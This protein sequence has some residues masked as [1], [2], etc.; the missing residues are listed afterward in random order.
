MHAANKYILK[1]S[2]LLIIRKMYIKITRRY[3]LTPEWLL[4]RSQKTT[5]VGEVLEKMEH[6]YIAGGNVN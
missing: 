5:N 1:C 2:S 3:Y 6:L 4:L